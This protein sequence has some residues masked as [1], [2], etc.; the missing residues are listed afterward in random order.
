MIKEINLLKEN[1]YIFKHA[2]QDT[3]QVAE[4][5]S[6]RKVI[7]RITASLRFAVIMYSCGMLCD[8]FRGCWLIS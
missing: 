6:N 8:M 4:R 3:R 2:G 5:V 7:V 1:T